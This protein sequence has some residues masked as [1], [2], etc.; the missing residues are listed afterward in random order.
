MRPDYRYIQGVWFPWRE[1]IL[2]LGE[3][4]WVWRTLKHKTVEHLTGVR[5]PVK[6]FIDYWIPAQF[7][8]PTG[9]H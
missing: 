6:R 3:V 5:D 4:D 9:V 8:L 1:Q 7:A 2:R